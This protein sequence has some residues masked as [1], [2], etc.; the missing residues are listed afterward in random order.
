MNTQKGFANIVLIVI[1]V[2]IVA[3]GGYFVFSKK[4]VT[5]TQNVTDQ[6]TST[7]TP[8]S[9]K[10]VIQVPFI[11]MGGSVGFGDKV[12][13]DQNAMKKAYETGELIG[14]GD[15]V[16]YVS[17]EVTATTQPLAA[18]YK[19]LFATGATVRFA[20]KEL[21]NPIADQA[22][23]RTITYENRPADVFKP[24]RFIKAEIR[25]NVAMVYL[26]GDLVSNECNDPR[27]EAQIIFTA[28]QFTNISEVK[29]YLNGKEF[30]WRAWMDQRG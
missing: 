20:G 3:V 12:G 15:K 22:K 19:E 18:A 29:T 5:P 23:E 11:D 14:C 17:K 2:G 24:L 8:I 28:K 25:G 27:V 7:D 10:S 13:Y 16:V 26:E 6:T 30:N 1:V 21:A 4:S 9:K